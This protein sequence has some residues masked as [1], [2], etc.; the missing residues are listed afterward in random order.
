MPIPA[1][2][3]VVLADW[4]RADAVF[5]Y[6]RNLTEAAL[7][8]GYRL[9]V[10]QI[11]GEQG[12]PRLGL[13]PWLRAMIDQRRLA[14]LDPMAEVATGLSITIDNAVIENPLNRSLRFQ[15]ELNLVICTS[16][17]LLSKEEHH[18]HGLV[19]RLAAQLRGPVQLAAATDLIATE[20]SSLAGNTQ[21]SDTIWRPAVDV[22]DHAI[23][24]QPRCADHPLL[25]GAQIKNSGEL[26]GKF[27]SWRHR[28]L[29]LRGP[30][31]DLLL[32]RQTWPH[33]WQI[34]DAASL[35]TREFCSGLDV[36]L[37]GFEPEIDGGDPLC[38]G[39]I[40]TAA[41]GGL[42]IALP[43]LMPYL[44]KL[45]IPSDT[46]ARTIDELFEDE[47]RLD[48]ARMNV[49]EAVRDRH[50]LRCHQ[51]RFA[52]LIGVPRFSGVHLGALPKR[53]KRRALFFST[54]G[55]G[56]GHLTRQL[57]IARR[58]PSSIEPVFLSMSQACGQVEKFGFAVEYT[59]YHQYYEGHVDHWNR[60]LNHL[61]NEM[62]AFYDPSVLVFDGN[63]PFRALVSASEQHPG[64]PFVWCRRGL[65][66]FG[67]NPRALA[68]ADAFDLV[69]EPLDLATAYD[70]G[71]TKLAQGNVR[72]IPPIRLLNAEEINDRETAAKE[73][74]LDPSKPA[75]LLQL[76]SR[77]N[78]D[79]GPLID[80]LLPALRGIDDL[81]IA[82]MQWLISEKDH[83]WPEDVRILSDYPMGRHFAAF[84]FSIATPGYNSF[85]ELVAHA[86]PTIFVP[87]ENATMD[88]H[89]ARAA[90]AERQGFGFSLRRAEVYKIATVVEA[91]GRPETR[92]SM[93]KAAQAHAS[94]NGAGMAAKALE[95]LIYSARQLNAHLDADLHRR[96]AI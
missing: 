25:V 60:H 7:K 76:G 70:R 29:R 81:Q 51:E 83:G 40:M 34:D 63:Y 33:G 84:D 44:G 28:S 68:R 88:D 35:S 9:A 19:E 85:H 36:Y 16:Q 43:K 30:K 4:R 95:E 27:F 50:D 58:L 5:W 57:A 82:T 2:D 54:N 13:R 39:A 45:A 31:A 64:R 56:M 10:M 24:R 1:F 89:V 49:A 22:G 32:N 67:Q 74:G 66:Q 23:E 96:T 20:L 26:D 3:I 75:M 48:Q 79:L 69:I 59:P 53:P 14:W 17:G 15:S 72:C 80:R 11:D 38:A 87:N 61:L 6:Q 86:M 91:I 21:A 65:W 55:V 42:S 71:P 46:P 77:N 62:I 93:R 18:T 37:E 78:Y 47:A 41:S 90:F 52:D 8:A 92:A 94:P 12:Q 73:L